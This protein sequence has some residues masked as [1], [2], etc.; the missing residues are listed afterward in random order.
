MPKIILRIG[1]AA[2]AATW[3]ARR[4]GSGGGTEDGGASGYQNRPRLAAA[5]AKPPL[6]AVLVAAGTGRGA[7]LA[8]LS[9]FGV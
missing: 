6:Q 4:G 1:G 3:G 7:A 8:A 5:V 2:A 9:V